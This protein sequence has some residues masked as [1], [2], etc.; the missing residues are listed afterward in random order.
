MKRNRKVKHRIS[1]YAYWIFDFFCVSSLFVSKKI[2]L[3]KKIIPTRNQK[4]V[5]NT[6]NTTTKYLYALFL[7]TN[8]AGP[9]FHFFSCFFFYFLFLFAIDICMYVF[10]VK[11]QVGSEYTVYPPPKDLRWRSKFSNPTPCPSSGYTCVF[12]LPGVYRR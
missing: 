4:G 2:C 10:F 5:K 6:S 8:V 9:F 7:G 11:N 1:K 3:K 12:H